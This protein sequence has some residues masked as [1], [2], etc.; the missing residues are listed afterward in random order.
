MEQKS[1]KFPSIYPWNNTIKLILIFATIIDHHSW[2]IELIRSQNATDDQLVQAIEND[3]LA[4]L[5]WLMILGALQMIAGIIF[6][7][8]FNKIAMRQITRIRISFFRS[9]LCQ[10]MAWYD[11]SSDM[12]FASRITE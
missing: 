5:I 7:D 4:Y 1:C 11:K 10:E 6:V 3:S 9:I 2:L 12:N 8:I